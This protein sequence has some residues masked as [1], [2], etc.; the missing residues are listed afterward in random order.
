[1]TK[2]VLIALACLILMLIQWSIRRDPRFWES[3]SR[4]RRVARVVGTVALMNWL[5]VIFAGRL[6]AYIV[7]DL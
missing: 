1:M 2:V 6:I 3:S 7:P 4:K 5:G